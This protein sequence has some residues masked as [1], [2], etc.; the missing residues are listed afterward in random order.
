[1]PR[2]IGI[3]C[4]AIVA[5][6]A[7][8]F[9][10][11]RPAAHTSSQPMHFSVGA[12]DA[13]VG[14]PVAPDG[15][16]I[17]CDLPDELHMKNCGGSDGAGLCV[18]TSLNHSAYFQ[19]IPVLQDFQQWMRKYPGGSWPDKTARMIEKRAKEAGK[20]APEFIQIEGKDLEILKLACK[21]GRMPGVTY[22]FSPTGR[23]GGGRI[24]HM[25]SLAAAGAGAEKGKGPGGRGWFCVIDNNYPG[26]NQIEWLSEQLFLRTYT[27]GGQGWSVIFRAPCPPPTPRP[28]N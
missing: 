27:G 5:S 22:S 8:S 21:T 14:G 23:Y 20:Q 10:D 12:Q 11:L 6:I 4:L 19:N 13:F 25:V 28:V 1:M 18:F 26:R 7:L 17:Q 2:A 9:C 3:V 16:E 24:S 15:T